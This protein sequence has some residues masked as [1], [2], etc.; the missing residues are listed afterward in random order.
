[1]LA[2][3]LGAWCGS[4]YQIA[5]RGI[6]EAIENERKL[7]D[8]ERRV[9][10]AKVEIKELQKFEA[11][12]KDGK[13]F[14][15]DAKQAVERHYEKPAALRSAPSTLITRSEIINEPTQIHIDSPRVDTF[16]DDDELRLFNLGNKSSDHRKGVSNPMP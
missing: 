3:L 10:E 15:E 11:E 6:A 1:M 2:M 13:E 12:Q 16:F 4:E 7:A 5:K 9:K 14:F 8:A